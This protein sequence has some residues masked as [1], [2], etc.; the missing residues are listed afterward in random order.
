MDREALE[1]HFGLLASTASESNSIS[2]LSLSLRSSSSS[3]SSALMRNSIKDVVQASGDD[4]W[5]DSY[6]DDSFPSSDESSKSVPE[7]LSGASS[8]LE[9]LKKEEQSIMDI[10]KHFSI[11]V[12]HPKYREVFEELGGLGKGAYGSVVVA[13]HRTEGTL[14]AIKK[15]IVPL[16]VPH[17]ASNPKTDMEREKWGRLAQRFLREV[18]IMAALCTHSHLVRYHQSWLELVPNDPSTSSTSSTSTNQPALAPATGDESSSVPSQSF[19][20]ASS[21]FSQASQINRRPGP[22]MMPLRVAQALTNDGTE[23]FDATDY[24]FNSSTAG[25][26]MDNH[27]S[28]SSYNSDTEVIDSSGIHLD[29]NRRV[30]SDSDSVEQSIILGGRQSPSFSLVLYIQME[31]CSGDS[32]YNWLRHPGRVVDPEM[33]RTFFSQLLTGLAHI[34]SEGYFHRD[35]KPDNLLIVHGANG[36]P[37]LK[38]GDF[39]LSK[40]ID[41]KGIDASSAPSSMIVAPKV[42]LAIEDGHTKG[43]GTAAYMAPEL[44]KKTYDEKVDI[45]AAGIVLFEMYN[46]WCTGSERI[47]SVNRLKTEGHLDEEFVRKHPEIAKL[48]LAMTNKDPNLRPSAIDI[49]AHPSLGFASFKEIDI[50]TDSVD[51]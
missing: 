43:R 4:D 21:T 42:T 1:V 2:S 18:Q 39:G 10:L 41:C 31:L 30:E 20:T 23:E 51:T 17:L 19:S 13:R 11:P 32:L 27:Q 37:S 15:V 40:K 28:R 49:L 22:H 25:P 24:S 35:I 8:R 5:R 44:T 34:H 38:L 16:Y 36:V 9:S 6:G 47:H 12:S 50:D 33:N 3:E 46:C 14:Y 48:V 7:V 45:F 26:H 29:G